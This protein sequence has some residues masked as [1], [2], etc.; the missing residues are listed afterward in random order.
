M[1]SERLPTPSALAA[2]WSLDPAVVILNHGSF[3][4]CPRAVLEA[5]R[6]TFIDR[7]CAVEDVC[8]DLTGADEIFLT[9]RAW[10]YW[11]TLSPL[12]EKHRYEMKPEAVWQI[13]AGRDLTGS[14]VANAMAR[15]L[16]SST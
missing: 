10:N 9:I 5:Q 8:P 4:A 14:D 15:L 12:L 1:K 2:Q 7:G 16:S 11:H 3:G 6:Q 13:E